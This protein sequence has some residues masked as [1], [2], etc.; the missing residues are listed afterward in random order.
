MSK[1][2]KKLNQKQ[3]VK[4]FTLAKARNQKA[5]KF[6]SSGFGRFRRNSG[7][8]IHFIGL[9]GE[10]GVSQFLKVPL[11]EVIYDNH[12]DEGWDFDVKKFGKVDVKTTTY[13]K[14]PY[15]RIPVKEFDKN[16]DVKTYFLVAVDEIDFNYEVVGWISRDKVP[17]FEQK[18]LTPTGP[19]NY[20]IK[21]EDL[22]PVK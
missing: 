4:L 15:L 6:G 5:R 10:F 18:Q 7:F 11:N 16:P 8:Y 22:S 21:R 19:L 14:D 1:L 2:I 13:F 12:G 20:I 9:I 17:E 3:I